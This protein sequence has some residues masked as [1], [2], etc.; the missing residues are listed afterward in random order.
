[1][2]TRK[3][4]NRRRRAASGIQHNAKLRF[5]LYGLIISLEIGAALLL[6][7]VLL[8]YRNN[9]TPANSSASIG[10]LPRSN[11]VGKPAPISRATLV[12]ATLPA[13]QI[14]PLSTPAVSPTITVLFVPS[15]PAATAS[16]TPISTITPATAPEEPQLGEITAQSSDEELLTFVNQMSLADKMGQMMIVGFH[17]TSVADSPELSTLISTYRVGGLVLLEPN[18]HDPQQMAALTAE[19]QNLAAIP[20]FLSINYEGGIVIHITEGVTGFPGNMAIA[21]SGKPEYAYIAA[22]L[23]AQELRALGFNMNLAPV[24]DVNDTPLNPVIGVRSFGE[25]PELVANLGR[26]TIRGFQ[27]NGIIAVAKHFPGHGNTTVDSHFGLPV[28]NKDAAQLEQVELYP[29]KA[30]IE[31]NVAAIMTAHVVVPAWEQIPGLPAS[32][33]FNILTQILR[34][35]LG[36]EGMIITDSL[37]MGA[38]TNNWGQA[39]AA[40]EAVKAGSDIALTTGPLQAQIAIHQALIA[41]VQNGEIAPK[42]ID[43]AVF[44]IL[45]AKRDYGLFEWSPRADLSIVGAAEHQAAADEMA[46]NAITLFKNDAGIVPLPPHIQRVL[47]LSPHELPPATDGLGTLLGQQ[48]RQRGFGVTE[49]VFQLGW[50]SN[51]DTIYA[52][53]LNAVSAHDLVIFGEWELVKRYANWADQ[54]QENLIRGLQQ[55]GKPLIVVSW[56]DPGTIIR[57]P[58]INTFIIAYG[59]TEA[60]VKAVAQIITGEATARGKL[61]L[62]ITMP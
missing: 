42:R 57:V 44:R 41:A 29:F 11:S 54:W 7:T 32:L 61:P 53:A 40:V 50:G 14:T 58:E 48:F 6:G 16:P 60:Q 27:Q 59:I 36:F 17:G 33:S 1:M 18:A 13:S 45:R 8:H 10:E 56:R 25:S 4:S 43:A 26:E 3:K 9:Q 31:Q 20:L 2:P 22:T 24:L 49:L 37:G 55:S 19:V 35:R 52:E 34:E 28:I 23:T 21:A 38:V 51:E 15:I 39:Q 46:L 5:V 47:I 30:A 62:T 12:L